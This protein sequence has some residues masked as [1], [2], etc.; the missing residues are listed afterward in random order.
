MNY[1][2][3]SV[4]LDNLPN[5]THLC[6]FVSTDDIISIFEP[7]LKQ[8]KRDQLLEDQFSCIALKNYL[9]ESIRIM[10]CCF[11]RKNIDRTVY[12]NATKIRQTEWRSTILVDLHALDR[13]TVDVHVISE[14]GTTLAQDINIRSYMNW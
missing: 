4:T 2:S 11:V 1:F 12:N 5:S 7:Q 8:V 14:S 9:A 13:M 3:Y 6:N 10:V